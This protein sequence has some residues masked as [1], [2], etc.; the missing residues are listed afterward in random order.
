[1]AADLL[2]EN[3]RNLISAMMDVLHATERAVIKIP[4]DEI[5]KLN[6]KLVVKQVN[7]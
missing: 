1:M 4:P 7:N 6:L 2:T 3:A 5:K